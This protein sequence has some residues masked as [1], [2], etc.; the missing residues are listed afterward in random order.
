L[1]RIVRRLLLAYA[2]AASLL[3]GGMLAML[4]IGAGAET[5]SPRMHAAYAAL[6]G[7]ADAAPAA[8][9]GEAAGS[10]A[11]AG[12]EASSAVATAETGVT[13]IAL[14]LRRELVR[15]D[16]DVSSWESRLRDILREDV[17]ED[18]AAMRREN[19]DVRRLRDRWQEVRD[20][21]VP[22]L[23][24]QLATRTG[25]APLTVEEFDDL[26]L[27]R[28]PKPGARTLEDLLAAL[29]QT[30]ASFEANVARFATLKPSVL[31]GILLAGD[32]GLDD[33]EPRLSDAQAVRVLESLGDDDLAKVFTVL[34]EE[35]PER[36]SSLMAQ[37]LG[38]P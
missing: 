34:Q 8:G 32:A 9:S 10:A 21:L 35:N 16:V 12:D 3:V 1:K 19:E 28:D 37:F 33:G 23:N 5:W 26:I 22:L 18:L 30:D 4:G 29:R 15:R 27:G 13:E 6:S 11:M 38:R 2:L 25:V 20:E 31:A 14:D 7:A 24:R 17:Q 36:A